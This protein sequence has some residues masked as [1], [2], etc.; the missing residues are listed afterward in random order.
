MNLSNIQ[1]HES[2]YSD[3]SKWDNYVDL[4]KEGLAYHFFAWKKAIEA[5]Y[6]FDCPYFFAEKNKFS[7]KRKKG[8]VVIISGILNLEFE[9]YE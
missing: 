6:G 8:S 4:Q 7:S 2:E 3:A 1:I 5:S 9:K